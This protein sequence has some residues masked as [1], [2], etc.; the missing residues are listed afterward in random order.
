MQNEKVINSLVSILDSYLDYEAV[1]C[2]NIDMVLNED[3]NKINSLL[4]N[5]ENKELVF[6]QALKIACNRYSIG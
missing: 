5:I 6:S 1:G 4:S 2:F 3:L